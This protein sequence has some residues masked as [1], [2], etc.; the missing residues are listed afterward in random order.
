MTCQKPK[1]KLE[2]PGMIVELRNLKPYSRIPRTITRARGKK[3]C[4]NDHERERTERNTNNREILRSNRIF[5][6]IHDDCCCEG[7]M[8]P[9]GPSRSTIGI[10]RGSIDRSGYGG[11]G[12]GTETE[13]YRNGSGSRWVRS[14]EPQTSLRIKEDR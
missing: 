11:L 7:S 5:T 13:T 6:E 1:I 9:I 8:G 10:T 2:S 3:D 12:L 14:G 4:G